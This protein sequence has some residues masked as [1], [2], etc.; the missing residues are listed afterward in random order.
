MAVFLRDEVCAVSDH[1]AEYS[2]FDSDK[3]MA[4]LEYFHGWT[5]MSSEEE[6]RK[7]VR[8]LK[9]RSLHE[10]GDVESKLLRDQVDR[11]FLRAMAQARAELR[12]ANDPSTT[13]YSTVR[14]RGQPPVYPRNGAR[15]EAAPVPSHIHGSQNGNGNRRGRYPSQNPPD[16]YGSHPSH[17]SPYWGWDQHSM[18]L[19]YGDNSSVHSGLSA[20]S[21]YAAPT[22]PMYMHPMAGYHPQYYAD[23]MAYHAAIASQQQYKHDEN[24]VTQTQN[25]VDPMSY[26]GHLFHPHQTPM[27]PP[28]HATPVDVS[29][30]ED[31]SEGAD[32]DLPILASVPSPEGN[33][34]PP[35]QQH[36][37]LWSH[38]D[39]VA[40]GLAT[41]GKSSPGT[42]CRG[43]SGEGYDTEG[44]GY[45]P[46]AQPPLLRGYPHYGHYGARD[47]YAPPSP[48]TQFMMSTQPNF[49][50]YGY[51]YAQSPGGTGKSPR[52]KKSPVAHVKNNSQHLTPPP[53]VHKVAATNSTLGESPTTVE[54][55]TET[56]SLPEGAV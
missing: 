56:E 31:V 35:G 51:S 40:G 24:T 23:P 43:T 20:D 33:F 54:T 19:P 6:L 11:Q 53:S 45:G 21:G 13:A 1:L 17:Q 48:A 10:P 3:W 22:Y 50:P 2:R 32:S 15:G 36:S 27:A 18:V 41:P 7:R 46:G 5:G 8:Q 26:N 16:H 29:E 49:A 30:N 34:Q 44:V 9:L 47:G 55:T 25:W 37:P 38:L 28:Y 52:K 39:S 12:D 42:P 4:C 14:T